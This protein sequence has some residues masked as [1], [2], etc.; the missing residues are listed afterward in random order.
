[1]SNLITSLILGGVLF[2]LV[3]ILLNPRFQT[4]VWYLYKAFM[5]WITSFIIEMNPIA[6]LK[7]YIEDLKERLAKFV[8]HLGDVNGQASQL[9]R[10]I[11]SSKKEMQQFLEMAETAKRMKGR[12]MDVQL[13]AMKAARLEESI[14][15]LQLM[16]NKL[17]FVKQVL[18]K[19]KYYATIAI[20][21]TEFEVRLNEIEYTAIR[22]SH[23]AFKS[24]LSII[25]GDPDKKAMFDES[26]NF[27]VNDIGTKIGEMD[28]MLQ[29]SQEFISSVDIADAA[30]ADK[31]LKLLEQFEAKG[32]ENIFGIEGTKSAPP[33]VI[34]ANTGNNL[35]KYLN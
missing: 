28:S 10:Q 30:F 12:E 3:M 17:H 4:G 14:N 15:R 26:M 31:G 23:N 1:M 19:M 24:A 6:I 16:A 32:L 29:A 21:K 7:S 25:N 20:D 22:S 33:V 13:N 9:D 18:E 27:M 11:S 5:R 2:A 8:K 35:G 34:N